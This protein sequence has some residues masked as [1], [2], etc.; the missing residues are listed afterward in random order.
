M[1]PGAPLNPFVT[2]LLALPFCERAGEPPGAPARLLDQALR[3]R[4]GEIIGPEGTGKTTLL[5]ALLAEAATRRLPAA[6]IRVP[7]G[8]R[9]P[10]SS[11]WKFCRS[12]AEQLAAPARW[13]LRAA[14]R[15]HGVAL[16][17]TGHA[18]LGLPSLRLTAV[19][20]ELFARLTSAIL[21]RSPQAPALVSAAEA[22]E[23]LRLAAGNAREAL[24]TLYDRY[25][26]RWPR[27]T[28]PR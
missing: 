15:A 14:C 1:N 5:R 6:L 22:P 3:L 9:W 12:H 21:A 11:V 8:Q 13:L 19:D 16:V 2:R 4:Q 25:E 10:T 23:A 17:V 26:Q 27:V 18:P 28:P 20:D 7:G 24:F